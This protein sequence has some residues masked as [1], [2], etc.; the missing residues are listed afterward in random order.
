MNDINSSDSN[1]PH[2][3]MYAELP[4]RKVLFDR[5][6][7]DADL[8]L[9]IAAPDQTPQHLSCKN[10]SEMVD[11][12]DRFAQTMDHATQNQIDEWLK[13]AVSI[14]TR[15]ATLA[16]SNWRI[17]FWDA[18]TYGANPPKPVEVPQVMEP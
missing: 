16:A 4:W 18:V 11:A 5:L 6:M 2:V 8:N 10:R 7:A 9:M 17:F 1:E 3:S 13:R 15:A 12:I 14:E